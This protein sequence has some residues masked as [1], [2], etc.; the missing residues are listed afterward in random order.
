MQEPRLVGR[1]TGRS[2]AL[3]MSLTE[4]CLEQSKVTD[5]KI[6]DNASIDDN[7]HGGGEIPPRTGLTPDA[8]PEVQKPVLVENSNTGGPPKTLFREL[9]TT[10]LLYLK[11]RILIGTLYVLLTEEKRKHTTI[12]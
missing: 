11:Q 3:F 12:L 7:T 6:A 10:T 9:V 2:H 5:M 1:T 8:L 4:F